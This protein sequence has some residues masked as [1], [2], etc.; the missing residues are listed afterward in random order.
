LNPNLLWEVC[1]KDLSIREKSYCNFQVTVHKN[2]NTINFKFY[3]Q[4]RKPKVLLPKVVAQN[5][6][7]II[8]YGH[9]QKQKKKCEKE[10]DQ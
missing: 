1:Y 9:A 6:K 5:G 2:G 4:T 10:D 3:I 8:T 7:K